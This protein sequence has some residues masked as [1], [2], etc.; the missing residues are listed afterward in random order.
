MAGI[1]NP[2]S[3]VQSHLIHL[4]ILRSLSLPSLACMHTKVAKKISHA[5]LR[6]FI[7]SCIYSFIHLLI[8]SFIYS[9]INSVLLL[10]RQTPDTAAVIATK[11]SLEIGHER[12]D[13]LTCVEHQV[14]QGWEL[15]L[16]GQPV[17]LITRPL[18]RL[19]CGR[20]RFAQQFC[21]TL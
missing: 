16:Q 10:Y 1:S 11:K 15:L 2:L 6:L 12:N 17:E 18:F 5:F 9:F 8:N 13:V 3:E 19:L 20:I 4:T 14:V 21:H 7:H